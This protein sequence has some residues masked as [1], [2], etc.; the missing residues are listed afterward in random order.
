MSTALSLKQVEQSLTPKEL[1]A[2]QKYNEAGKP[3]LSPATSANFLRLYLLGHD[4][5]EIAE[6]NP[7]FGLGI[8]VKARVEHGWDKH[9]EEHLDALLTDMRRIVQQTQVEAVR[10]VGVSM[11]A[12]QK[13]TGEKFQ[14]Y[15]QTGDTT[16]LGDLKDMGFKQ[17]KDL[18]EMH[19]KLTGQDTTKKVSGEVLHR[20]VQEDKNLPAVRVDKPMK[21]QEAD[22]LLKLIE[23]EVV[24]K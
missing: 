17:Y 19:L 20:H 13:L 1:E 5:V 12:F 16:H 8:I 2:Y 9:K 7:G 15:I 11:A 24:Q 6:L 21:A 10:F 23:G 3:P 4:C 18:I 22:D 14:K